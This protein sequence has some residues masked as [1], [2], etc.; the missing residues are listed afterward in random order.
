MIVA[1]LACHAGGY[2]P[3]TIQVSGSGTPGFDGI[4]T[5]RT[6]QSEGKDLWIRFGVADHTSNLHDCVAWKASFGNLWMIFPPGV[7]GNGYY[8][9]SENGPAG[10]TKPPTGPWNSNGAGVDPA[11]TI[12]YLS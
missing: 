10:N 6:V 9:N 4:Y 8:N 5:R 7:T 12:T 11:P 2:P 3:D 1:A